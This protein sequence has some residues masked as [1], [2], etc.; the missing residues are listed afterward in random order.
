MIGGGG[1]TYPMY[2][3]RAYPGAQLE[4]VEIDP[5]VTEAAYRMFGLPRDT[6]IRIHHMDARN[7][8][9]SFVRRQA[10]GKSPERY[11]FIFTDAVNSFSVPFHLTTLEYHEQLR[12]LLNPGG[13][14]LMTMIDTYASAQ[15]L[16]A[17]YNTVSRAF[18]NTHV[19]CGSFMGPST[20]PKTRDTFI[21]V[22]SVEPIK[23]EPLAPPGERPPF[24]LLTEENLRH[25]RE[26][27]G[28]IVLTDNFA[29]VEQLLADV[30]RN[31]ADPT[32]ELIE[33]GLRERD[34]GDLVAAAGYL[35]KAVG[36]NIQSAV[37]HGELG[38]T[39]RQF[40]ES[41]RRDLALRHLE[42]ATKLDPNSADW[43]S[44][45]G[46]LLLEF[47]R[48][49]EAAP[50]LQ[51]AAELRREDPDMWL[52]LGYALLQT[53]RLKES[54]AASHEAVS[55]KPSGFGAWYNLAM[56]LARSGRLDEAVPMMKKLA[57]SNPKRHDLANEL[58]WILAVAPP[59]HRDGAAAVRCAELAN[60]AT[61]R[62]NAL[63]LDTLAAAYAA[64]GRFDQAV[65][66]ARRSIEL[67]PSQGKDP[68]VV[69]GMKD[70]LR[71]YEQGQPYTLGT[72]A[73]R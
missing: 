1:Y 27:S 42:A 38:Q 24:A 10:E 43:W 8:V 41:D 21:L 25:V 5:L 69:Q 67:Y 55:L 59:P 22:G 17:M 37:A 45:Y 9:E 73:G 7:F 3:E 54:I 15:F 28:G 33:R 36:Y 40:K 13:A 52:N 12:K 35:T 51:R 19:F 71:L 2:M 18:P 26:R 48:Y 31:A 53:G 29:P 56:A 63:Y 14:Y 49:G 23:L 16:G 47:E 39:L 50:A 64:A 57:E 68:T 62:Q 11:D 34:G 6:K 4:A 66:T 70:R 20:S 60:D 30:V 44:A 65:A 32:L 72:A 61:E 58:A 46:T